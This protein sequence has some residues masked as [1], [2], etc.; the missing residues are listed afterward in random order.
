VNLRAVVEAA[1]D[2]N[3]GEPDWELERSE[4]IEDGSHQRYVWRREVTLETDSVHPYAVVPLEFPHPG[5][6]FVNR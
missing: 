3:L 5:D 4:F 1:A 2:I 6:V